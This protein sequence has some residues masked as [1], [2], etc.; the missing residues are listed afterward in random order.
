MVMGIVAEQAWTELLML[1]PLSE[2]FEFRQNL[3]SA[4]EFKLSYPFRHQGPCWTTGTFVEF[5]NTCLE[6]F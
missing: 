4:C 1:V 3:V 2:V 6:A 5:R